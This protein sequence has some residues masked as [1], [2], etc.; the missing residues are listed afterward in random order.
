MSLQFCVY[1]L[2]TALI[3]MGDDVIPILIRAAG[4]IGGFEGGDV[5]VIAETAIATAEGNLARLDKIVPSKE[6]QRLAADYQMDPR[7]VEVVLEESD[8]IIG[9]IP[10]FLLCMKN[11]T[12]L[13]NAG[14]D[15]SNAP[16]GTVVKLPNNPDRSAERI[17]RGVEK[18]CGVRIGVII[19]DSR[20]HAMRLGCSGV[21]IGC[22]GL[23]AVEDERGRCDL[24]GR[25]LEVTQAAVADNIASACELVMGEADECVPAAVVRGLGLTLSEARGVES[26]A[27]PE[28]LFMGVALNANPSLFD[29]KRKPEIH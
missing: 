11:G 27:A 28:C 29:G 8:D 5:L 20:T 12:L 23:D 1:G 13:P 16:P 19:A 24:Y 3:S 4:A 6:A 26:I 22:S 25:E 7:L 15:G 21:A 9:G 18:E 2:T 14:I 17:R 10:G